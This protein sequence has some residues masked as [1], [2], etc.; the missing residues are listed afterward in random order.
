[1]RFLGIATTFFGRDPLLRAFAH[2]ALC[3]AA[4]LARPAAD[5]LRTPVRLPY[6]APNAWSAALIPLS[7]LVRRSC[8]FL[9]S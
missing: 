2:R 5:I 4:I 6:A 3:A 8:S 7:S 9:K 1:M